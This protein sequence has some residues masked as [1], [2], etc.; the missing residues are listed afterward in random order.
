M[1]NGS[2]SLV[3]PANA[4]ADTCSALLAYL[5]HLKIVLLK[6]KTGYFLAG[7]RLDTLSVY[8]A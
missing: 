2:I 8:G 6:S 1:A 4:L 3:Q 7:W 5:S